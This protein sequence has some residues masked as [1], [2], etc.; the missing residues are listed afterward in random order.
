MLLTYKQTH[1]HFTVW[2][3]Q[4]Y[5]YSV[6]CIHACQGMKPRNVTFNYRI[7]GN[8]CGAK[9]FV[10]VIEHWTTNILPTNEATLPTFTC[11]A[12]SNYEN[13]NHKLTRYNYINCWTTSH[14]KLTAIRYPINTIYHTQ[15]RGIGNEVYMYVRTITSV[16]C[17]LC[18]SVD[19]CFASNHPPA[20]QEMF[21]YHPHYDSYSP[22]TRSLEAFK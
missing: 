6:R 22:V 12:S 14:R 7:A 5:L 13:K 10:I 11:S 21:Y 3:R 20:Q 2:H 1:H 18:L 15:K 8:F 16:L 19:P 9:Y 4:W 17:V